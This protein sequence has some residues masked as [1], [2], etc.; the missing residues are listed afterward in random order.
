M[1]VVFRTIL[2]YYSWLM[3]FNSESILY[4]PLMGNNT[5]EW[6]LLPS[7]KSI[8][9]VHWENHSEFSI[10]CEYFVQHST[11]LNRYTFPF[12]FYI[13]HLLLNSDL[14]ALES[15]TRLFCVFYTQHKLP[16]SPHSID[17]FEIWFFI[18]WTIQL[19]KW[20]VSMKMVVEFHQANHCTFRACLIDRRKACISL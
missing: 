2:L 11:L 1:P 5:K 16:S 10:V 12:L 3:W 18:I 7:N 6:H 13:F 9:A 4:S 19:W 14:H 17:R 20:V 15:N 8:L